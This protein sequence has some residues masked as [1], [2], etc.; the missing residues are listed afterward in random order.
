MSEVSV[1]GLGSMGTSLATALQSGALNVTVWN[2]TADKMLPLVKAGAQ[3][4]PSVAAAVQASPII[5]VCIDNYATTRQIMGETGVV[6]LLSGKTLI[7]LSTG[8]PK[9]AREAEAW[10]KRHG[11]EYLDGAIMEY[12]NGI[13]TPTTKI[14]FAG[15]E[16]TFK[17]SSTTLSPLGGDLKY[18]GPN[19]GAA[20][21]LDLALLSKQIALAFGVIHGALVCK[22]EHVE[23]E[24]FGAELIGGEAKAIA[25]I[26]HKNDY[27]NPGATLGVLGASSP[28]YSDSSPRREY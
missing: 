8:T 14:L 22:S 25:K 9:E 23:L 24:L 20:A 17:R 4:A 26:I 10:F 6:P 19:I 27:S 2:R 16:A 21:A 15:P 13:G 18:V 5:L 11:A 1:I 28:T 7:Q 3:A 12:P